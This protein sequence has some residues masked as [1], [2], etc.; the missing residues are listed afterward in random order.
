VVMPC[1]SLDSS[2]SVEGTAPYP[3]HRAQ[4]PSAFRPENELPCNKSVPVKASSLN[5]AGLNMERV[6]TSKRL[7]TAADS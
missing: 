2:S 1:W 4:P 3:L 5:E 6:R 7:A